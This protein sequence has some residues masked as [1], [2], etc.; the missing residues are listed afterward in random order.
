[1]ERNEEGWLMHRYLA[2]LLSALLPVGA[3]AFD[4]KPATYEEGYYELMDCEEEDGMPEH[5]NMCGCHSK[6][7]YPVISLYPDDAVQTA[8]N[9][10]L[11]ALVSDS[12]CNAKD[13][14]AIRK[15]DN[16]PD[17][18]IPNEYQ[19]TFDT[20]HTSDHSA[21]FM[22]SYYTYGAGAAHGMTS[23]QGILAD[24]TR[25][26]I[27]QDTVVLNPKKADEINHHIQSTLKAMNEEGEYKGNLWLEDE[28]GHP[29]TYF[30]D[31]GCDG[32]TIYHAKDG[33]KLAF[34]QYA[35]ASYADGIIEIDMPDSFI[36]P[37]I[38][39]LVN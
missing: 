3:L 7:E 22:M 27:Y 36:K 39:H 8:V 2:I 28:E 33:W 24:L 12:G 16:N 1:M 10:E 19:V 20:T 14:V 15:S 31:E 30:T 4:V 9:E 26:I 25:G 6:I 29:R 17:E 34:Q 35:I 37:S 38:R 5:V 11:K 23:V 21:S 13:G 18:R 32:C